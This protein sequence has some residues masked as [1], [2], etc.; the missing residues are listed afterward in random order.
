M[1]RVIPVI[2]QVYTKQ[3]ELAWTKL[4]SCGPDAEIFNTSHRMRRYEIDKGTEGGLA[5]RTPT[6]AILA[7]GLCHERSGH[8]SLFRLRGRA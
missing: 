8:S 5:A 2:W 6:K 1:Q 3:P 7:V 4:G